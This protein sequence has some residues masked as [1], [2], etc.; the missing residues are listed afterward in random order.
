MNIINAGGGFKFSKKPTDPL[1]SSKEYI[2]S[3]L[4]YGN[5]YQI[6]ADWEGESVTYKEI[7]ILDQ[8]HADTGNPTLAYIKGNYNGMVAKT[9]TGNV[10]YL[11]AVPGVISNTGTMG[12]SLDIMSNAL[13]G[14]LLSH[15]KSN[16]TGVSF[17]PKV[18]YSSGALPSTQSEQ[19]LF[20]RGI[21]N[22][23]SGTML[24]STQ[25]IQPF[26]IAANINNTEAL[27]ILGKGVHGIKGGGGSGDTLLM[28]N[29][30]N[31][32]C[33]TILDSGGSV[34]NGTYLIDIDGT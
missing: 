29:I 22:A 6:K 3:K 15:G 14:T 21:A 33:K 19:I 1:V 24:A 20:A 17:I 28:T 8:V 2:Y 13:S 11:L 4:S 25:A 5:T 30:I 26:I 31:T 12:T 16:T 18:V 34:G 10:I 7:G 23:Y 27:A 9:Q 32:S